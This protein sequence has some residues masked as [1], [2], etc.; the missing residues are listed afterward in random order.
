M[1]KEFDKKTVEREI[2]AARKFVKIVE[3]VIWK[4]F[5]EQK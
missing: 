3:K 1:Y 2:E 4:E 5:K